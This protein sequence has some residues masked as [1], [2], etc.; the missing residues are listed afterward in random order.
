[1][2]A[3]RQRSAWYHWYAESDS[4]DERKLIRKLDLL[5]VPYAFL[6]YW[7]KFIDQTNITNAYVS[8]LSRGAWLPR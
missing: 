8:G 6:G 2:H 7:I 4:P 1:M 3:K 5:I